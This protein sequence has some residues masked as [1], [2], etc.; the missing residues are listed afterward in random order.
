MF[1]NL[2][3]FAFV[4]A[5]LNANAGNKIRI[6]FNH[7]VNT[8]VSTG[9]NAVYLP[10]VSSADTIVAYI[11]R[12]KYS[13][14]IA[15]FEYIQDASYGAYANI[16]AAVD[17]A[18]ARGVTVRWIFDSS[19]SNSGMSVLDPAIHTL[20]R[21]GGSGIMH[22]KFIIID[23]NSA[24]PNDPVVWSGS[25]DWTSHMMYAEYN[26]MLFLQ[27]QALARAYT[28][29]FNQMWGSSTAIPDATAAKF[30]AA[31]SDLGAHIFHIDGHLVEL[32]FSPSD[33]TNNHIQDAI[34]SANTDLYFGMY[35]FTYTAN[36]NMIVDKF[37][38]GVYVSGIDDNFSNP[39]TPY[40]L[41]TTYLGSHFKVYSGSGVYHSK[42]LIV[43]PSDTCSDPLV[44]TGSHNWSLSADNN[45]DENTLI[46]HSDTIANMYYQS[47]YADFIS[48]GG[49]L[50]SVP[51]CGAVVSVK[52]VEEN[53]ISIFPNPTNG[54]ITVRYELQAFQNV[55]IDLYDIFGQ[56][57]QTAAN[58][59]PQQRGE[60]SYQ[61]SVNQ[62]GVYY[63]KMTIGG[64]HHTQK[65]IVTTP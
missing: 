47:F 41:F 29:E 6:Y 61:L 56:R 62:P 45:N 11:D 32:Y 9:V 18:Y 4:A 57:I 35:T 36:A 65:I 55:S 23:A 19:I 1:K 50:S 39:Y 44:L 5:S 51:G 33:G 10:G 22:N 15:Q 16:A 20:T 54:N 49:T 37:H 42:E 52:N 28:A 59:D 43:D 26:N 31:K 38:T 2:L 27:D 48:L 25:Y 24:D 34:S 14:D 8:S 46:I 53:N 21:P 3:L 60:H 40:D 7:P 58:I 12:A 64:R 13:I 63:L 17:S 30:G